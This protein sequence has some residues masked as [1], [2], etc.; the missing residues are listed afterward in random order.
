M[1]F[2][3]PLPP[4]PVN[5]RLPRHDSDNHLD[6]EGFYSKVDGLPNGGPPPPIPQR[7]IRPRSVGYGTTPPRPTHQRSL[8]KPLSPKLSLRNSSNSTPT[9]SID[10]AGM[11]N[12]WSECSAEPAPPLPPRGCSEHR[13]S[14]HPSRFSVPLKLEIVIVSFLFQ[15]RK[16]R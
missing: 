1:D 15:R 14:F 12:S 2:S 10:Q 13:F 7:E 11:R 8:S 6:D 5:D 16:I 3:S 4:V 9:D